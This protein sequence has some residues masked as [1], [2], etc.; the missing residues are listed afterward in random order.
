MKKHFIL[1]FLFLTVLGV[2]AQT[3]KKTSVKKKESTSKNI[4]HS[5]SLTKQIENS[6]F[7]LCDGNDEPFKTLSEDSTD[8][9]NNKWV[10]RFYVFYETGKL[11]V[12]EGK[13]ANEAVNK[14]VLAKGTW[15][16]SGDKIILSELKQSYY[17]VETSMGGGNK[18][19]TLKQNGNLIEDKY[20]GNS[21]RFLDK[22]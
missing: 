13:N 4:V 1:A 22:L 6:I 3:K 17:G 20:F 5:P 18:N 2:N 9:W 8:S 11:L 12:F 14:G 10:Y 21:L 16:V 15:E 19:Y 7:L